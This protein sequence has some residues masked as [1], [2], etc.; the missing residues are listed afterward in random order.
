MIIN[1]YPEMMMDDDE[2]EEDETKTS[3]MILHSNDDDEDEDDIDDDDDDDKETMDMMVDDSIAESES[4]CDDDQSSSIMNNDDPLSTI[5]TTN[6]TNITTQSSSSVSSLASQQPMFNIV[7][8][9][10]RTTSSSRTSSSRTATNNSQISS[11]PQVITH[12]GRK[13]LNGPPCSLKTLVD[14]GILEPMDGSLTYEILGAKFFGDLLANGFIRMSGTNQVFANPSSWANYCRSTIPSTSKDHKNY[15]SAWSI[16]RY[17]GKRL[18]SYKLRWYRKQKKQFTLGGTIINGQNCSVN[19]PT[20]IGSGNNT[21][22]N[23]HHNNN[24]IPISINIDQNNTPTGKIIN[25]NNNNNNGITTTAAATTTATGILTPIGNTSLSTT[26]ATTTID[27]TITSPSTLISSFSNN[28]N[29]FSHINS[30]GNF[31]P[32]TQQQQQ[33]HSSFLPNHFSTPIQHHQQYQQSRSNVEYKNIYSMINRDRLYKLDKISAGDP[34]ISILEN[35]P[36]ENII[37]FNSI[38]LNNKDFN[39]DDR[40]K[41]ACVPFNSVFCLQPFLVTISTNV[42]LLI[43]FHSHLIS[44]EVNGYLA[45]LWDPRTQH[46]T[47]TQAFPLRCKSSKEFDSCTL[48]IKQN[49]VQKG[50]ILVGWY[51]SHPRTAPHPSIADIKRQLKYQKQMLATKKDVR[52]YSPCV[53][54]ICSPFYSNNNNNNNNDDIKLTTLFQMFWVMPI[55]TM[56]NRNIGRPMQISYQIARDAFLTQDLLVEMRVLAAHFAVHQKFIKFNDTYNGESTS[57]WNKLQESLKT[58]LPRDLVEQQSQAVQNDIQ[59]Q[60]LMHFWSFLKNLLLIS[61]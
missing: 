42:L 33:Q 9:S 28:S 10:S 37:N 58:K 41:I 17:L 2:D 22:V 1:N 3:L 50:L 16:I 13:P 14:D 32:I 25:N 55:F 31:T 18:D 29:K 6:A 53:G 12:V 56:G 44:T 45:G 54:L 60:A 43:D 11:I 23:H 59:Q 4:G 40:T 24:S 47:I 48:K 49:L 51:H 35:N 46:L 20:V 61:T 57:Y 39:L 8:T 19:T 21:P 36:N 52:D 27:G 38:D 30:N 7:S 26:T 5:T 34:E 15:G